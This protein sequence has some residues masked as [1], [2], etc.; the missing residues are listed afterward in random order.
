MK[1]IG[2]VH[3]GSKASFVRQFAAI[4]TGLALMRFTK[5]ADYTIQDK[6][7][8]DK[9]QVL[10]E[11]IKGFVD[12]DTIDVVIAAGGPQPARIAKDLTANQI[13]KKPVVFTTVADPPGYGLVGGNLTG[14]AGKTSERDDDRLELLADLLHGTLPDAGNKKVHALFRKGRPGLEQHKTHLNTVAKSRQLDLSDEE[15]ETDEEID[16]ALAPEPPRFQGLLVTADAFF[17]NRREN[18]VKKAAARRIPAIYQWREFV[19]V[20]GLMSYGPSLIEAYVFAG[21]YAAR[22]LKGEKPADIPIS[23][24]THYELVI[25]RTTARD[26]GITIPASLADRAELIN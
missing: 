6:W 3:S 1:T 12:N 14:M 25:N 20:G 8:D 4:D 19:E 11:H 22:I 13:R 17:N 16:K 10:R 5:G 21:A 26:L 9:L 24:P 18:I 2:F 15:V 23:E 7:A